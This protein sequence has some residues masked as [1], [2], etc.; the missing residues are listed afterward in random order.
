MLEKYDIIEKEQDEE[1]DVKFPTREDIETLLRICRYKQRVFNIESSSMQIVIVSI[2][3]IF[4]LA[5]SQSPDIRIKLKIY[6]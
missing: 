4:L 3:I 1:G 5:V 6:W 2:V